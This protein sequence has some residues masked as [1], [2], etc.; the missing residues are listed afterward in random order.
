MYR[1][2]ETVVRH[3]KLILDGLPF[4]DG[5]QV[6]VVVLS[7]G[8]SDRS[9]DDAVGGNSIAHVRQVL[10]GGVEKFDSPFEPMVPEQTWEMLR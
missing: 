3:G 10:R 6:R 5:E 2:A 7:A 9:A 1:V 8:S 4:A